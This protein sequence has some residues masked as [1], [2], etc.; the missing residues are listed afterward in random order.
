MLSRGR[1]ERR[2]RTFG[3][4]EDSGAEKKRAK[5]NQ[6]EKEEKLLE[7]KPLEGVV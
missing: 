5:R 3:V 6:R 1:G 7:R 2:E 4:L